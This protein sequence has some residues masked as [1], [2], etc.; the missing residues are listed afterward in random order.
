LSLLYFLNVQ[1]ISSRYFFE[2]VLSWF[3]NPKI[4]FFLDTF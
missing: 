2:E 3:S 1:S 4:E